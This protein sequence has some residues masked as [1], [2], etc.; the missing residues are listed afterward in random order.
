MRGWLSLLSLGCAAAIVLAA[1]GSS[2]ECVIDTDCPLDQRCSAKKCV[3][4]GARD[5]G[6]AD[7]STEGG[8]DGA[9]EGGV[10]DGAVDASPDGALLDGALP[11]AAAAGACGNP[12]DQS[13]VTTQPLTTIMWGCGATTCDATAMVDPCTSTCVVSST[14]GDGGTGLT[15]T[16]AD[17][18]QALYHCAATH[19]G[20]DCG[21]YPTG[22]ACTSCLCGLT[23]DMTNCNATFTACS[24]VPTC[25]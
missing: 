17:C 14:T 21:A 7:G 19:C 23:G 24:G 16:C 5:A 3:P 8:M 4:V 25:M 9:V 15:M 13:I 22:A 10:G 2:S 12:A 1:C 11:D 6:S 20:I 18:Y